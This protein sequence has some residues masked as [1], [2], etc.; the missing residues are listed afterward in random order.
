MASGPARDTDIGARSSQGM[1]SC[2]ARTFKRCVQ[3]VQVEAFVV[4]DIKQIH[5]IGTVCRPGLTDIAE[6][7]VQST[8]VS[9][10]DILSAL[11][12]AYEATVLLVLSASIVSASVS[13]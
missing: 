12:D 6:I 13:T 11:Q 5:K 3:R 7:V 8:S 1:V 10:Q 4:Q 2:Q 9:A